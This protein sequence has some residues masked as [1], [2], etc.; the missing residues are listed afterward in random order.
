MSK[1]GCGA[2]TLHTIPSHITTH[3]I[4]FHCTASA[5]LA[6]ALYNVPGGGP[7]DN[8]GPVA[9]PLDGDVPVGGKRREELTIEKTKL[10]KM[11]YIMGSK[12]DFCN[13]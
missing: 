11:S 5:D 1:K 7:D 8:L 10:Q 9:L 4:P 2:T 6:A 3:S 12:C 13:P